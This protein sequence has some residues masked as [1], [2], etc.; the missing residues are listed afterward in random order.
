M[1]GLA[2]TLALLSSIALPAVVAA[3]PALT[4]LQADA[5]ARNVGLQQ[6][7]L[8]DYKSTPVADVATEDIW[9]NGRVAHCMGRTSFGKEIA[10]V[11]SPMYENPDSLSVQLIGS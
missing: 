10:D 7:D 5:V 2:V 8:P 11:S 1:R 6:S 4:Q 9:G 3:R